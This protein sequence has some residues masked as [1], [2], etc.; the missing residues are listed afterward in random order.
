MATTHSQ[1]PF[2][3]MPEKWDESNK[4]FALGLRNLFDILFSR[5]YRQGR[6]IDDIGLYVDDDGYV[7]Q[8]IKGDS[9]NG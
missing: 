5:L 6:L 2:P 3:P 7:C 1:Y 9:T 4:R 8:R